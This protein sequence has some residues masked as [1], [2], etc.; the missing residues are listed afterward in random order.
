MSNLNPKTDHIECYQFQDKGLGTIQGTTPIAV[1]LPKEVQDVLNEVN[2]GLKKRKLSW[3]DYLRSVIYAGLKADGIYP[4][5]QGDFDRT[6]LEAL[7]Q[8]FNV[9]K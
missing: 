4:D 6:K 9:E 2:R 7:I 8:N 1:R 5:A 3:A